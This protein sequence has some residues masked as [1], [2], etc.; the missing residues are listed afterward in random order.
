VEKF[1]LLNLTGDELDRINGKTSIIYSKLRKDQEIQTKRG[2]GRGDKQG[3]SRVIIPLP[4]NYLEYLPIETPN[5]KIDKTNLP[6]IGCFT[7]LNTHNKLNC[8]DVTQDGSVIVCGFKDGTITVWII[9]PEMKVEIDGKNFIIFLYI[10]FNS[11]FIMQ[12]F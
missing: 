3:V 8:A 12:V 7:I 10:N 1:V 9:N 4:E 5:L 6:T 2:R 11:N